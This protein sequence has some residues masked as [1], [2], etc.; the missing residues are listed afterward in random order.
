MGKAWFNGQLDAKD[1]GKESPSRL[2]CKDFLD[3]EF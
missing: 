1:E 2:K 3:E